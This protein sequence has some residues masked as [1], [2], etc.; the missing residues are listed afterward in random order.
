M[1]HR[2]FIADD[3]D[4]IRSLWRAVLEADPGIEIVGEAADGDAALEGVQ[5]TRPDV[6]MLD[7]AMPGRDGLEVIS[8][9]RSSCPETA[10]LV[11]SGFAS[12]RLARQAVELG[13]AAYFEKGQPAEGLVVLVSELAARSS[14]RGR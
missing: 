4:E 14:A 11:V 1:T 13:A 5:C 2:V 3:V 10:I 8:A 12:D 6:L 7:L 9:A